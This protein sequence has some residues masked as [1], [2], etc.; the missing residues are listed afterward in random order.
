MLYKWTALNKDWGIKVVDAVI[1]AAWTTIT[2]AA[3]PDLVWGVIIGIVEEWD[4]NAI[5][6]SVVLGATWTITVTTASAQTAECT[7]NVSVMRATWND[8]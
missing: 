6:K 1:A 4:S 8:A 2:T 5:V 3:D 7:Y